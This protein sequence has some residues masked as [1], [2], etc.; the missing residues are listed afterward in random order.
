MLKLTS[1]M[2]AA[3][4]A[5]LALAPATSEAQIR[6]KKFRLGFQTNLDNAQGIGATKFA[7]AVAQK[8]GGK[9]KVDIFPGGNLGGDLQT[10]SAL[11][12][13]TVDATILA[14]S[15]LVGL[16][17]EFSLFDLP[18]T[19][20]SHAEAMAVVDGAFGKRINAAL[21][22]RG[23]INLGYWGVGYRNLTN[24]R[25]P[26][27]TLEDVKG[28]KI[29]VLQNPLYVDLWN[30]L[31]ANAVPM[32]FPEVYSALE[33]KT[34]DGQENPAATLISSKLG[35]VQKH[36][37]LTRHIYFLATVLWSKPLWDQLNTDER[38]VIQEAAAEMQVYMRREVPADDDKLNEQVRKML[39]TS[40]ISAAE[41]E[42]FRAAA[43]P[44]VD[45][46]AAAADPAAAKELFDAIAKVR[47]GQ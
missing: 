7:E 16:V 11:R 10:V 38:K 4:V 25:R 45:K 47:S 1:F 40:D 33:Q 22:D 41:L 9:M 24:S 35:E 15:T 46:Y 39:Q 23:L 44:V 27:A 12:G 2:A 30:A 32:P 37:S 42:K 6:E 28:L 31:G 19:F 5:I 43:K 17:K 21:S 3:A 36:Y 29:R 14:T 34:V 20:Q 8:S 13:G 18:F 26:V